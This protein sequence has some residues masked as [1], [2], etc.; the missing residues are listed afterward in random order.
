MHRLSGDGRWELPDLQCLHPCSLGRTGVSSQGELGTPTRPALCPGVCSPGRGSGL[1]SGSGALCR[2]GLQVWSSWATAALDS[3]PCSPALCCTWTRDTRVRGR[4]PRVRSSVRGSHPRT[5]LKGA[6]LK[7]GWAPPGPPARGPA[8]SGPRDAAGAALPRSRGHSSPVVLPESW[9][10]RCS[11]NPRV[12]L[13]W[14]RVPQRGV[15]ALSPAP[16]N[17]GQGLCGNN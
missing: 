4:L 11:G 15:Q 10:S 6:S 13:Q 2:P 3:V 9:C 8:S 1:K 7:S 17:L 16:V 14:A 5:A 12:R